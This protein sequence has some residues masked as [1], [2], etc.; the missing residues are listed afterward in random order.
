MILFF[1]VEKEAKLPFAVSLFRTLFYENSIGDKGKL[2]EGL[3]RYI[4]AILQQKG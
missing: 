4:K 2:E 3:K 1:G